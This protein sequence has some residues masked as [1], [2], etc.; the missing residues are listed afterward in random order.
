[1]AVS[2]KNLH[3]G[4]TIRFPLDTVL[5]GKHYNEMTGREYSEGRIDEI[6]TK[7]KLVSVKVAFYSPVSRRETYTY[8]NA[9]DGDDSI[10][11][12]IELI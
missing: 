4:Q 2:I 12:G 5:M 1:M 7:G 11:Y 6:T 3:V 8:L 9:S 10:I